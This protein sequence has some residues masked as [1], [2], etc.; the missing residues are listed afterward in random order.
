[1]WNPGIQA[2]DLV[3]FCAETSFLWRFRTESVSQGSIGYSLCAEGVLEPSF[4]HEEQIHPPAAS[5]MFL[6]SRCACICS[7]FPE[8]IESKNQVLCSTGSTVEM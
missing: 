3:P 2:V 8:P 7:R 5:A 1:M 4:S 6:P